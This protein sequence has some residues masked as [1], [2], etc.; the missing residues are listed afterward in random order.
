MSESFSNQVLNCLQACG[1][2]EGAGS[3]RQVVTHSPINGELLATLASDDGASLAQKILA[4]KTAQRKWQALP[5]AI[6]EAFL[7][8][9][10]AAIREHT[11]ALKTLV[12]IDAGKMFFEAAGE[13][14]GSAAVLENTIA[15]TA[16]LE[17]GGELSRPALG[18]VGLI[19]SYNFPLAVAHWT[20]APALLAGN[21]VLWKPSEKTPLVALAI[22]AIFASAATSFADA[23]IPPQLLQVLLAGRDVGQ[24]MVASDDVAMISATGSVGMGKAIH[25]TLETRHTKPAPPV[26]ELGGNNPV[27]ISGELTDAERETALKSVLFSAVASSGQRCTDTRR[28]IVHDSQYDVT[29]AWLKKQEQAII[30][31][32]IIGN[33]FDLAEAKES[34]GPLI[35][36]HAYQSYVQALE[37]SFA[38]GGVMHVGE[39][40][41]QDMPDESAYRLYADR[42]PNAYYPKPVLVEMKQQVPGGL[43]HDE[44]FA[45]ILFLL[46]YS[47]F[48]Q[49]L[50]LANA[51][52]N[53]GLV[54]GIY[55]HSRAEAS[56]FAGA[57]AA[58]HGVINSPT[59][60]GTPAGGLGFGGCRDSG[61]GEILG[62]DPLAPFSRG[63]SLA[64][65]PTHTSPQEV[66]EGGVTKRK[67]IH[68]HEDGARTRIVENDLIKIG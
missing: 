55:T 7:K 29:L 11:D 52:T 68:T 64:K 17:E 21:A 50:E 20:I 51:P 32:G 60:T 40:T 39:A 35:D 67:Y 10:A 66:V 45:P 53:A 48:T 26:L 1:W 18:V 25:A 63:A 65:L 62:L 6:R 42:W 61:E 19:T 3:G 15:Q 41:Y 22:E 43:L 44:T 24:L 58:G 28:L 59:G 34:Y 31:K 2:R 38:A 9:Y 36:E 8:H 27:I 49:A 14:A 12:V 13:V 5:R 47:D 57:C 16:K 56:A 4:L 33:P 23:E 54:Q 46:R 30:D 37:R